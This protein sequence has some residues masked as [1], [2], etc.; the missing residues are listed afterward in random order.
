MIFITIIFTSFHCHI[1]FS[2]SPNLNVLSCDT[3][4]YD[5]SFRSF[6]I[7][8]YYDF[9]CRFLTY[10]SH[11]IH[12][13]SYYTLVYLFLRYALN[14]QP[15]YQINFHGWCECEC[16]V[17]LFLYV[18]WLCIRNRKEFVS[19]KSKISVVLWFLQIL[20]PV[21]PFVKVFF[22]FNIL[23][24]PRR[25]RMPSEEKQIWRLILLALLY[26]FRKWLRITL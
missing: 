19:V 15:L 4:Y 13:S 2:T 24:L 9:L 3:L 5:A 16:T 6:V 1:I 17:L 21:G 10:L 12:R 11:G 20:V 22:F 8:I 26:S 25:Y 18:V 14:V 23:T 7:F